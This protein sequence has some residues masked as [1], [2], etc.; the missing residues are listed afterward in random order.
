MDMKPDTL[1][2]PQ[3]LN[4]IGNDW[5]P[6]ASGR[7]MPVI[8]PIDGEV[9]SEIAESDAGDVDAA[10]AAAR[11]AFEHG[12][13]SRLTATERGRLLQAYARLIAEQTEAL[14]RLETRDNGKPIRQARADM[15]ATARYFEFYGGAADKVH[16]EI[17]PFLA[18]YDVSVHREPYGVVGAII[19]WNYPAQI[20]GRV[21]AAALAMGNTVVLKPAEDACLS[22]LRLGELAVEAGL[23]PGALNIVTGRGEVAGKALSEHRGLDFLTF[24]GSPEVGVMIQIAAARNFIPCTLE[25]GGKSPQIVFDDA[26]LDAALPSL[27][28]A[29]V[30]NGGQTCSAGSRVLVQRG[31]YDRLTALLAERFAGIEAQAPGED[32]LLGPLISARQKAR[33]ETYIAE[34]GAPVIAQGGVR[35]DAPKG[36]FYV[37]PVVFG[38]VDPGSRLAQEEV[39]GPVLAVIPFTDEAEAIRIANGTDYGLVAAV[40]TRDGG[41]QAR[42]AKAMHCGQV[43]INGFGAGG[44]VELP[45]GG[46]RKSGHGREKGFAA[47][48]EFSQI[49]TI[50][51]NHG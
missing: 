7:S 43:Y 28:N 17:I 36:G 51:N 15:V 29:I 16:G 31:I 13:W 23:P 2:L 1:T 41:R 24:T 4:L 12:D 34:A 19:P 20:Y 44:G 6:A 22:V 5:V 10:V 18:G 33:V 9:F 27:V 26:D 3:P 25:L 8:S 35:A 21:V 50:V 47:L 48:Y 46:V 37:P 11:A 45:F 40:W 38:P 39:F 14:A 49:K 42:V 30:Q 32:A